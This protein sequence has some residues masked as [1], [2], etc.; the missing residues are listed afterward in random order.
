MGTETVVPAAGKKLNEFSPSYAQPKGRH[1]CPSPGLR[2]QPLLNCCSKRTGGKGAF[3]NG[4]LYLNLL[5]LVEELTV[6]NRR[7]VLEDHAFVLV[8]LIN[9]TETLLAS[10]TARIKWASKTNGN[11]N[12]CPGYQHLPSTSKHPGADQ[13][14][15]P[16]PYSV[17]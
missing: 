16:N 14:G 4:E 10:A 15:G 11:L 1:R 17:V 12:I 6:L 2:S 9:L 8:Q 3:P 7:V 13:F 5:L